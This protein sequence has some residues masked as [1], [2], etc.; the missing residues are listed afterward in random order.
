MDTPFLTD[1]IDSLYQLTIKEDID[2]FAMCG[3]HNSKGLQELCKLENRPWLDLKVK[4]EIIIRW[5]NKAIDILFRRLNVIS[6]DSYHQI[7][8]R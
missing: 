7:R 5:S 1:R 2:R 8:L 4:V 3:N 6:S